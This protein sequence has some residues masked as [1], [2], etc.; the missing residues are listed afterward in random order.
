MLKFRAGLALALSLLILAASAP[1]HAAK[2]PRGLY[3]CTGSAS[4][5]V[6]SVKIKAKGQYL[7]ANARKGSKLKNAT[8]GRYKVTGEKI[9]WRSGTFKRSGYVSTI[10]KTASSP[11]PYFSLDR[12]ST[13]IWT[14]ISC[15]WRRS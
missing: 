9:K 4:G 2:L 5:Y 8:K 1:A 10:Y 3:D 7:Y 14:G 6:A 12:K 15:H 11:K 13:G